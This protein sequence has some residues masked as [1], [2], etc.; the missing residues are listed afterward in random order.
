MILGNLKENDI[1]DNVAQ[2]SNATTIAPGMYKLDPITLAP[3][4]KNNRE[5]HIYYLKHTMEQAAILREIVEQAKSLNPLDSASY[6]AFTKSKYVK[7][8]KKKEEWKP[9][10]KV[11]T[12]IGYNWRPT[13]RT[14]TLVRNACPLTRI[15]ATNKVP[16]T[17]GS[18]SKPK[19]AKS[20]ISN[21]T[22]PDTSR[23]SNT[24]IAP[25]SS[26]IVD[27]S[28]N[29]K[30]YILAIMDDYSRFTWVKFLASKDEAPDFII[31]FLKMIQVRLNATVRNIRTD[32]GTEF[33]TTMASEQ[34]GSGLGLQSMTP[35]TSSSGLV[36]NPIL[37]QPFPVVNAPR[38]VDLADSPVSTLID[39][40]APSTNHHIANVIRDPYRSVS[41]RKQLQT[42][43]MWCY[44]D[45]FLTS[46]EPKKF[47]QAMTKPSW[48]DAMQK[49]IH[50]FER[51]QVWELV[52]CLD[53][54]MLIKLKWIYKIKTGEFCGVLKNKARLVLKDSIK[55]R[56]TR[57]DNFS[58]GSQTAFLN[59]GLKEK[60]YVSQ[61]EGFVDQDNP[62]HV[63][64]LKKALYGL[65]Q[66]PHACE[67]DL[68]YAVCLCAW[69]QAKPTE[70]HLNVVKRIFR[71]L[72]G[73][74]NMGLWYSK[75][76]GDKLVN[77]S[78]NKQKC[79]AISS[80]KAEYIALFGCCAQIL[81]MRS[82]LIDYGFQFNKILLY[83]DNKSAIALCCNNV[84]HSRAKHIDNPI[85]TIPAA[86][87]FEGV[88]DGERP[89]KE[90]R[91]L[92]CIKADEKKLDDIRVIRDFPESEEKH[93]APV[94]DFG[95][96]S[97]ERSFQGSQSPTEW[98]R[99]LK[100]HFEQRDDGEIYFFDRI[101]I[102]LVGGVGKLIMDEAHTFRYS[103]HPGADKMYYDMRDLYWWSGMKR[104][105]AEYVVVDRLTKSAH[106]L[107]IREIYTNEI[108]ARHG[109]PVSI[110][111]DRVGRFTSHLWQAF[112]KA[113][114]TRL[115]MSTA[116]HPETDGQSEHTI[117]TLEDMLR[118]CVMD[119]G[120][121]WDTHLPLIEFS[122]NNSYHTSIKCAPFEALY[123]RKCRSPV[124]W[125][126]VGES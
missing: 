31:K 65:K 98:L 23:G 27:L 26:S 119:F 70:K 62:S 64:K 61:P 69:Y 54:V 41:T 1:V 75:D 114:G 111:S 81:W 8:A 112:Q 37:Q 123:G 21:K 46:V 109:V 116:Y 83:C 38:A 106:F 125:T 78:S 126:K 120:G 88:T 102:P 12:K 42:D 99:G 30:N 113:L 118:A 33:L 97:E 79:T 86:L 29:G 10:G 104:D 100:R 115:D 18:N 95:T 51:L 56:P 4:D 19:I 73:T 71:Y 87:N 63:Y 48:I 22:E 32:N 122:Y 20:V 67:P 53:K 13:G 59:G 55:R 108:V 25:S 103:V 91:S 40:D 14:F 66:A 6:S 92:A 110:I 15:T 17:N 89:E 57:Y 107:P 124:I 45:A 121:S 49:E 60:V 84:Q 58:N 74:I 101:W 28:V 77:W 72:K 68:I 34:L 7:K 35:A 82:Q 52:S 24:S 2:V 105:I 90:L 94:D 44:F 39:Q 80:T 117:Q 36:S 93:E 11:F 5:T 3:K 47:K 16:K 96:Y 85:V 76:I 43:V 9:T 50:K